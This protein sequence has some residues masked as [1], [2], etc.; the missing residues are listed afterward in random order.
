MRTIDRTHK[1]IPVDFKNSFILDQEVAWCMDV[2][3]FGLSLPLND[4]ETIKD[5]VNVYCEWLTCSLPQPR[6]SVPKPIIE[7][8]NIYTRKIIAHLHNLFVPRQGEGKIFRICRPAISQTL[9]FSSRKNT[10]P[11]HGLWNFRFKF[12]YFFLFLIKTLF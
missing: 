3:C 8:P 7:D 5:C 4:H 9:F 12:Y 1:K 11:L 2:I 10:T 6:V